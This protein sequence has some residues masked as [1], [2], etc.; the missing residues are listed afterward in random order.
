[1]YEYTFRATQQQAKLIR[2][3]EVAAGQVLWTD[4]EH[5]LHRQGIVG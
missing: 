5:A 4:Y 1:M 2:L 3:V